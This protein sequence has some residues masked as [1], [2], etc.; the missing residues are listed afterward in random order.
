MLPLVITGRLLNAGKIFKNPEDGLQIRFYNTDGSEL[1]PVDWETVQR[2]ASEIFSGLID[3][4]YADQPE[5]SALEI[6]F[7]N[8]DDTGKRQII[9]KPNLQKLN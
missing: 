4:K 1:E 6:S 9:I 2:E 5:Y 8:Q 7:V 3:I